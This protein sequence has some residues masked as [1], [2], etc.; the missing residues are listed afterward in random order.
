MLRP[1]ML[2]GVGGD[3]HGA[4]VVAVDER[5]LGERSVELDAKDTSPR[6]YCCPRKVDA[7]C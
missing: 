1:L 7:N 5:A 6:C 3:V 4:D 2:D